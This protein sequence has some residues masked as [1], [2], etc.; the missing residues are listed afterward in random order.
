MVELYVGLRFRLGIKI[1][2]GSF[3]DI[4][5]GTNADSREEVAIKLEFEEAKHPQLENES[6]AYRALEGGGQLRPPCL[7]PSHILPL[8]F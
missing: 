7:P 1:G 8:P 5:A 3:G 6:N 4:Y 2:S